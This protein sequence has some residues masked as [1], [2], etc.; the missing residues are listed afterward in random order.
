MNKAASARLGLS[1]FQASDHLKTEED[2][3]AYMRACFEEAPDDPAFLATAIGEYVRANRRVTEVAQKAGMSR[4][5]IYKALSADGN[6]SFASIVKIMG[7]IGLTLTVAQKT[8][9]EDG[10]RMAA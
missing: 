7:A 1:T 3:A 10:F 8:R 5:G 4:E 6:P 2:C 9:S